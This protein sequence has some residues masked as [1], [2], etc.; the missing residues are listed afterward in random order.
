MGNNGFHTGIHRPSHFLAE[1]FWMVLTLVFAWS[2]I[3][4][5]IFASK[6]FHCKNP[7]RLSA[8]SYRDFP[9][10]CGSTVAARP[11]EATWLSSSFRIGVLEQHVFVVESTIVCR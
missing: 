7:W 8:H 9:L 5:Q 4:C 6:S 11:C 3:S 2:W 10:Y 1:T